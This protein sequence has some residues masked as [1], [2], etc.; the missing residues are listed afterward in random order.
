MASGTTPI[1]ELYPPPEPPEEEAK[2]SWRDP[3]APGYYAWRSYR[4]ATLRWSVVHILLNV[5]LYLGLP[6]LVTWFIDP[7]RSR[8][9][10]A[11]A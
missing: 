3:G 7:E 1:L 2:A 11:I 4:W 8:R 9:S 6:A 5:A 10:R